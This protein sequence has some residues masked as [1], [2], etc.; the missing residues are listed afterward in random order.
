MGL[1]F[2]QRAKA[3]QN[4]IN[5]DIIV[6]LSRSQAFIEFEPDG[7]IITANANFLS[8]MGYDVDEVTGRHHTMFLD[9]EYAKS[10]E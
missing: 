5:A 4:D 1:Q 8:V 9:P 6:A 10:P 3:A 7:T 2:F